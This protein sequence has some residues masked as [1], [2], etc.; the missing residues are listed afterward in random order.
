M[1]KYSNITH[2]DIRN[3][4]DKL[5]RLLWETMQLKDLS[6]ERAG[7]FIGCSGNQVMRWVKGAHKPTAPYRKLIEEG[8]RKID[9]EV[10]GDGPGGLVSWRTVEVP[11]EEIEESIDEIR[12]GMKTEADEHVAH[13]LEGHLNELKR[14]VSANLRD[15]R[16]KFQKQKITKERLALIEEEAFY[17]LAIIDRWIDVMAGR[18]KVELPKI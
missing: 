18:I 7:Q 13:Y 1:K 8:I 2:E 6:F 14:D 3:I 11:T 17:F 15:C 16:E 9:R 10:P 5:I 12:E 4:K